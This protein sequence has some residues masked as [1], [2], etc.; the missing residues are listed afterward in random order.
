MATRFAIP[1]GRLLV[2][3]VV[4]ALSPLAVIAQRGDTDATLAR[5]RAEGLERSAAR[6]LFL[7]LT[8]GIGARLTGSPA[9]VRAA[10]WA[11]ER[12]A[13]WGLAN[14]RLEPFE[15]GAGWELEH[16]AAAMT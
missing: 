9:H 6:S 12:F 14:A 3:A 8:D 7:T 1:S 16:I 13:E 5:I 10:N 4:L 2:A 15:F 11:R